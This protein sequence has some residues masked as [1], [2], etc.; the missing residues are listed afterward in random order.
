[1]TGK[2]KILAYGGILPDAAKKLE[3]LGGVTLDKMET[4]D[5]LCELIADADALVIRSK[6]H[7]TKKAIECAKN[8]KVIGRAGV[9]INNIDQDAQELCKERGIK[10]INT[11]HS[12]GVSVAELTIGHA[13]SL[14]R[15]IPEGTIS[16]RNGQ[17][18]RKKLTGHELMGKTWGLVAFGNIAKEVSKRA[19]AF[20]CKL[21]AFD[22]F[23]DCKTCEQFFVEK[24]DSLEELFEKSDIISIHAP[25]CPETE[26]I[27]NKKVLDHANGV[28]L[29]N[30][31]RG[32]IVVL[33]DI[34]GALK[35]GKLAGFGVDVYDQE[36]PEHHKL[37]D[38]P[39]VVLTP[40]LG[41]STEEGQNRSMDDLIS[42]LAKLLK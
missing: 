13:I 6:P 14:L 17:W 38:L 3:K 8:L 18:D 23:C 33:D 31:S 5:T 25:L 10:I 2:L 29:I 22:P 36:P 26:G 15:N 27:I 32:P 4:E 35:S 9:A 34:Y 41:A 11:P 42:E 28:Y 1:M 20:G 16:L 21:L 37:F 30:I 12:T 39:N 24:A 40:H 19:H 7:V